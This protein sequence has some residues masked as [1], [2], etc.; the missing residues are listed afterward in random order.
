MNK[1]QLHKYIENKETGLLGI[2]N[3][4]KESIE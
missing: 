1:E 2:I 3:S 4:A